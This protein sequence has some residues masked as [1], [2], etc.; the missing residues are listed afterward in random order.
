MLFRKVFRDLSRR[1][2]RTILTVI[3]LAIAVISITGFAIAGHSV[4]ESSRVAMALNVSADTYFN[5]RETTWNDTLVEDV[6]GLSEYEVA[7]M[8]PSSTFLKGRQRILNLRGIDISRLSNWKSLS[9]IILDGGQL[10][11]PSRNEILFDISSAS[12]MDLTLGDS[13][14]VFLPTRSSDVLEVN[15]TITGFARN[16]RS[17][18]YAFAYS[19]DAW[20]P[21]E[22]LQEL[23]ENPGSFNELYTKYADNSDAED[24][25]EGILS[26]FRDKGLFVETHRVFDEKDDLRMYMLDVIGLIFNFG[27]LLGLIISGVLAASTIQIIVASE[28]TDISLMKVIG[29]RRVHVFFIYL[30]E[31]ISLGLMGSVIG[32]FLSV[33]GGYF[34]LNTLAEPLGLPVV[35]F[36]VPVEPLIT[37]ALLPIF[38]SVIFSFPVIVS[39]LRISPMETFRTGSTDKRTRDWIT[40]KFFL[41]KYSFNNIFRKKIR[42]TMNVLILC[43]AVGVAV[44]FKIT[45]D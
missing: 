33:F 36:S 24:I 18:G 8:L 45:T 30:F 38:T 20:L 27:A 42:L 7:L 29:G 2:L 4:V 6:E 26:R 28:R 12:A 43:L 5:I 22:R 37:G 31:A 40:S 14:E 16:L 9:G 10:P 19:L 11:D 39:V 13:V 23:L 41:F 3:G 34:L 35:V 25:S 21:L 15:F 17:P 32:L 1:K 44:G